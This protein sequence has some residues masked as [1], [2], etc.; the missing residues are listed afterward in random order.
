MSD[1]AKARNSADGSPNGENGAPTSMPPRRNWIRRALVSS[2]RLP[3]LWRAW[4]RRE[5]AQRR[6]DR[7]EHRNNRR[8]FLGAFPPLDP[9]DQAYL[10]ERGFFPGRGVA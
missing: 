4:H 3:G 7:A 5:I 2:A 1:T 10:I 8:P 6:L 9:D